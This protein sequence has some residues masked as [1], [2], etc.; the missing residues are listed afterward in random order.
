MGEQKERKRI[1]IL[2]LLVAGAPIFASALRSLSA[3]TGDN[4]VAPIPV[5]GEISSGLQTITVFSVAQNL[6]FQQEGL[7]LLMFVLIL[8][9]WLTHAVLML[10]IANGRR[11]IESSDTLA[12]AA[13]G[14]SA[15][16]YIVL[17]FGVYRPILGMDIPLIQVVGFYAIPFATAGGLLVSY[18]FYPWDDTRFEQ[19]LETARTARELA[20]E[21]RERF[22][23]DLHEE[24]GGD[25]RDVSGVEVEEDFREKCRSVESDAA[26]YI[27]PTRNRDIAGRDIEELER[28]TTHLE[29]W[30]QNLDISKAFS[31]L[32]G[33]LEPEL[34]QRVGRGI[35]PLESLRRTPEGEVVQLKN[36]EDEY[37]FV[38]RGGL[39]V[40][41]ADEG[42]TPGEQVLEGYQQGTVGLVLALELLE[43]V[44][45]HVDQTVRP[46]VDRYHELLAPHVGWERT[47]QASGDSGD[48]STDRDPIVDDLEAIRDDFEGIRGR[49]GSSLR[50]LYVSGSVTDRVVSVSDAEASLNEAK[51]A[52]RE[53]RFDD[54]EPN[55]DEARQITDSLLTVSAYFA[56]TFVHA[57]ETQQETISI[58]D[59]DATQKPVFK[60]AAFEKLKQGAMKDYGAELSV[61]WGL[62]EIDVTYHE[63]ERS[64]GSPGTKG[65]FVG[66]AEADTDGKA[67]ERDGGA[68]SPDLSGGMKYLIDDLKENCRDGDTAKIDLE[69]LPRTVTPTH[70]DRFRRFVGHAVEEYDGVT[71]E[72]GSD[73]ASPIVISGKRGDLRALRQDADDLFEAWAAEESNTERKQSTN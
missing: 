26:E 73:D 25:Y 67:E 70:I 32:K 37:R 23:R 51:K 30:A 59:E 38:A 17:F 9:A 7:V 42:S 19:A 45:N 27:G 69:R 60:K 5:L 52:F 20:K 55:L 16:L 48:D 49:T 40:D 18:Q 71:L 64:D 50:K 4:L 62:D 54:I 34:E 58:T 14:I 12:A 44:T 65:S 61:H 72:A 11:R 53:C 10:G 35:P 28:E 46:H 36:L 56:R 68:G 8:L 15:I 47:D 39:Q 13:V 66:E 41:L 6:A 29:N 31:E 24:L 43:E 33:V 57:L 1:A 63:S 3:L 21:K 22:E 2:G